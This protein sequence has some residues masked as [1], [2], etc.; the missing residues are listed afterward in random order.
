QERQPAR[1]NPAK[2]RPPE[3]HKYFAAWG[4]TW[5]H[6]RFLQEYSCPQFA[7]AVNWQPIECDCVRPLALSFPTVFS[8]RHRTSRRHP[9]KSFRR[10]P[11][12]FQFRQNASGLAP[13]AQAAPRKN[14]T[15]GRK[16][17]FAALRNL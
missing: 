13:G 8:A 17:I 2:G 1:A 7:P 10:A 5:F 15:H 14:F 4:P 6:Y 16:W 3:C 9:D 12:K 11:A